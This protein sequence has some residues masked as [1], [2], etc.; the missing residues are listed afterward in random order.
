MKYCLTTHY[1]SIRLFADG[2]SKTVTGKDLNI[3]LKQTVS[4][5]PA[6]YEWLCSNRLTLIL[7]KRKHLV[8]QPRRKNQLLFY[9]PPQIWRSVSQ[10]FLSLLTFKP[11]RTRR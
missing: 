8:F 6:I 3:L 5:L 7:S 2:T 11:K 1:F 9:A 10:V 4:E